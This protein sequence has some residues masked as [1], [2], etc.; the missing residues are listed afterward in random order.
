LAAE[1]VVVWVLLVVQ[2]LLLVSLAQ[3]E[4]LARRGA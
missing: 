3:V 1:Q 4:E 2:A